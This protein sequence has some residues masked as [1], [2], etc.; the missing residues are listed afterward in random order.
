MENADQFT[1]E[2]IALFQKH[3]V[4]YGFAMFDKGDGV[5][6]GVVSP[7]CAVHNILGPIVR[8]SASL[9]NATSP[10]VPEIIDIKNL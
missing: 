10:G 2:L 8:Q 5:V 6:R 7:M 4:V 3:G 1:K 9:L